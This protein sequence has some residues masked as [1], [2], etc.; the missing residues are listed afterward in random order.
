MELQFPR[1]DRK[2]RYLRWET[3]YHQQGHYSTLHQQAVATL[4]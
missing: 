3:T 1:T 4:G 2:E